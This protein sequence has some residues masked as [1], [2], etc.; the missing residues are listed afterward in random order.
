[1]QPRQVVELRP[2]VEGMIQS[3]A[4]D[5][6]DFVTKGQALV[7]LQSGVEQAAVEVAA[8]RATMEGAV[9]AREARVEFATLRAE[10]HQ[11]LAQSSFIS[12]QERDEALSEKRLAE[13]EL[14]EARENLRL[15]EIEHER[16]LEQLKLRTLLSPL[17][18]V[19]VE[20]LMHPGDVTNLSDSRQA[21][22]RIADIDVLNVEVVLPVAAYEHITMETSVEV[23]PE[24]RS[25]AG[26]PAKVKT[27]DLVLDA[28]SGTFGVRLEL[29]NDGH[30]WPGGIACRAIFAGVPNEFSLVGGAR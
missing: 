3:I 20:R 10:R 26:I 30:E 4:V 22:L 23:V 5:R 8:Y 27:I 18:G 25:A 2:A 6:G 21:V 19:V 12:A 29:P 1:M 7:V 28:A 16:A 11:N 13:A 9:R 17:S 14:V 24:I 15:A